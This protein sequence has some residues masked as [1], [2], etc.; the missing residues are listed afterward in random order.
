MITAA[1]GPCFAVAVRVT[2]KV[3]KTRTV[4]II[5]NFTKFSVDCVEVW[6]AIGTFC[7]DEVDTATTMIVMAYKSTIQQ[8]FVSSQRSKLSQTCTLK[9]R[10]C[11]H[12]QI[13]CNTSS[14]YYVQH[15]MCHVVLRDS[16]ASK[17]DR[18]DTAFISAIFY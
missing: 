7:S 6:H 18:V 17:S 5:S 16:S 11:N 3:M 4:P 10:G 8:F 15:V 1:T 12:M 14:P 9:W 13:M 2:L